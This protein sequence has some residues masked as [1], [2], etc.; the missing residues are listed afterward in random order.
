[1]SERA[2]WNCAA[3]LPT[4]GNVDERAIGLWCGACAADWL[5]DLKP[6]LW[7]LIGAAHSGEPERLQ[8]ALAPFPPD[9]I[10]PAYRVEAS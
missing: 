10:P 3:P 1:M 8:K 4:E 2:C 9:S 5:A 6:A 7:T